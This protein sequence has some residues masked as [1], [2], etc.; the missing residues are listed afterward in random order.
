MGTTGEVRLN[1]IGVL[2]GV[3]VF[4]LVLMKAYNSTHPNAGIDEPKHLGC[5]LGCPVM[6]ALMALTGALLLI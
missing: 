3:V 5:G 4:V 1:G 2:I 6:V